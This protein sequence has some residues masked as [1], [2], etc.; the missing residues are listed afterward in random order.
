MKKLI[1]RYSRFL[2]KFD[3]IS[4]IIGIGIG[5]S[6][7]SNH[8]ENANKIF[9]ILC[10]VVFVWEIFYTFCIYKAPEEATNSQ[11]SN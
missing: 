6:L 5:M 3:S 4:L 11:R 10:G 9:Y 2:K 7:M 8:K 1:S